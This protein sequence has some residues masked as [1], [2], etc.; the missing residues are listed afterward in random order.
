MKVDPSI[1]KTYDVRG[2]YG[3]QINE[4]T[5]KKIAKAFLKV[6]NPFSV[7]VGYDAR[8]SS[9][10]LAKVFIKVL[11]DNGVTVTNIG[12]CS[13]PQLYYASAKLNIPIGIM[14]TASH[15]TKEF[16]GLKFIELGFPPDPK[17]LEEL[18]YTVVEDK[19]EVGLTNKILGEYREKS[20][21]EDYVKELRNFDTLKFKP[22][23]V[24][25]DC[26]NSVNGPIARQ[27]FDN[28]GLATVTY[29][30]ENVDG[31]FP[32]HETNPK[33][34]ANR[35]L[36]AE[37]IKETQSDLG[38]MWDGDADRV[39]FLD[40]KG[41]VIAPAFVAALIGEYLVKNTS[42][43]KNPDLAEPK[44]HVEVRTAKVVEDLVTRIGGKVIVGKAWH[45]EIKYA[46]QKD[47]SIIFG[48]E[49]SGHYVFKN[50]Y[51]IDDGMLAALMF[52][53]AVSNYDEPLEKVLANLK[54]KYYIIEEVNFKV[55]RDVQEILKDLSNKYLDA[56]N[57]HWLDGL[58][59]IY[60][61]WRFNLRSSKTEPVI[62]LNLSA[63]SE[64]LKNEKLEE[65]ATLI[66]GRGGEME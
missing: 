42:S 31:N 17:L 19:I 44:V 28:M 26:G 10:P 50:F 13:T 18:K 20:I 65:I 12:L 35:K 27:V 6:F 8:V 32:N 2:V 63:T 23:N 29:L 7:V 37:K 43:L 36:L 4:R 3:P 25:V 60:S 38:I 30:F 1:F 62:R 64:S 47:S 49:T 54:S 22:L 56:Q 55:T 61:D 34:E 51:E 40:N 9:K 16:T 11:L 53:Q 57:Q 24:V 48:S 41:E 33:V 45:T 52:L 46:M 5:L 39:Y 21:S 58:T 15:A 59:V 66:K 14:I